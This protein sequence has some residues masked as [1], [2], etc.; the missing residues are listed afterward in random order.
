MIDVNF[1]KRYNDT[2]GHQG[3]DECLRQVAAAMSGVVKR[4]SDAVAR[5]GGEEF[6]VLMPAT[7]PEGAL[8]VAERIRAAVEALHLP[9][10]GSDVADHVT[11]SVG[12]ASILATNS[13]M[14]ARLV[15]AADAALYRAKHEGRNRAVLAEP[16]EEAA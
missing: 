4:A 3:G 15:A 11:I 9:H 16:L 7:E 14:P 5:Y 2:Y 13:G 6:S 10:S 12:V 8:L 1:F